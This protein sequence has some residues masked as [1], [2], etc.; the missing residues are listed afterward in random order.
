MQLRWLLKDE[1][2]YD[3]IDTKKVLQYRYMR[4]VMNK[5]LMEERG[6]SYREKVWSPWMDV[7]TVEEAQEK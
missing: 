2:G 7:E 5:K 6:S 1:F 3:G 4:E